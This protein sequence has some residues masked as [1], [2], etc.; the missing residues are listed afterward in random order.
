MQKKNTKFIVVPHSS[1]VPLLYKYLKNTNF[2]IIS[3][4]GTR[5]GEFINKT[6]TTKVNTNSLV[7]EIH[8]HVMG[9]KIFLWG[10]HRFTDED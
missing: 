2:Q 8:L 7:Y 10:K 5:I 6:N 1:L 3:A 9:Q 4:T